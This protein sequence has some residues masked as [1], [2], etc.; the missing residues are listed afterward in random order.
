MKRRFDAHKAPIRTPKPSLVSFTFDHVVECP[1][2]TEDEADE[3]RS[4]LNANGT[5]FEE[6]G[7]PRCLN[8]VNSIHQLALALIG[9]RPPF[10]FCFRTKEDAALFKLF[11]C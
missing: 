10:A 3:M 5:S 9:F 1:S 4:W 7:E 8:P 11:W 2:A 6:S